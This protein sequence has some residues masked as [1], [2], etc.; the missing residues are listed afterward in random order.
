MLLQ[1]L[2]VSTTNTIFDSLGLRSASVARISAA[3]S[4]IQSTRISLCSCGLRPSAFPSD[5]G[6]TMPAIDTVKAHYDALARRDLDAALDVIG[7]DAMWEFSSP[8][9]IPFAGRWHGR[10]G[11]RELFERIRSTVE[12]REF[13]VTR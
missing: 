9:T 7:D 11:V 13:R 6:K 4:G 5:Q 8:D 1:F 10:S 12:V 3:T 2:I